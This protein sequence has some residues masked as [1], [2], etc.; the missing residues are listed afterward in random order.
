[1]FEFFLFLGR[2]RSRIKIKPIRNTGNDNTF[3]GVLRIRP[4][5]D[6]KK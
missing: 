5:C 2:I 3:I 1:M 4:N 6:I